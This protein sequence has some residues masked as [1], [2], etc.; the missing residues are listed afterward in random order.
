M[1]AGWRSGAR[2]GARARPRRPSRRP[3]TPA[4]PAP[5]RCD[6]PAGAVMRA[7]RLLNRRR[8]RRQPLRAVLAVAAIGAGVSLAVCAL[9]VSA[10][11]RHSYAHFGS[12]VG[13][14]NA[15]R[16]IGAAPRGGLDEKVADQ[17][18]ATPGVAGA[19]PRLPAG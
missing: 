4:S 10:S 6:V 17:V 19:R 18:A 16:V 9:I 13:G 5:A 1:P 3:V 8:L 12:S 7:I 2:A 14:P 11:L 15:L